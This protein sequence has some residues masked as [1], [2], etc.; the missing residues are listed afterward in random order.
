MNLYLKREAKIKD[1][2]QRFY[3]KYG[4][5]ATLQ[6]IEGYPKVSTDLVG[7]TF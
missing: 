6:D 2:E 4:R 1:W 3:E 7:L 5:K